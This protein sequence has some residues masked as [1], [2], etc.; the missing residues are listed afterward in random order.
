VRHDSDEDLLA[1]RA[2]IAVGPLA[3]HRQGRRVVVNGT[4]GDDDIGVSGAVNVGGLAATVTVLHSE[5]AND[6][7]EINTLAG[8]DTVGT[9]KLTAGVIQLFV[10]GTQ[11]L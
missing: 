5:A 1:G 11:A 10:N 2:L 8:A 3:G 7:L 9:S 6:R 4:N